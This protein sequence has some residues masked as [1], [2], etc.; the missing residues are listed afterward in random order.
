MCFGGDGSTYDIGLQS[1]SGAL[2]RGHDFL[3]VCYNNE[4]YMNTGG[5]RSGA[6]PKGAGTTTTPSGSKSSGKIQKKK[7]M[8]EI[9]IA[10]GIPYAA[11]ASIFNL[12]DLQ[13]KV[14][15][16]TLNLKRK[17]NID[18]TPSYCLYNKNKKIINYIEI[19]EMIKLMFTWKPKNSL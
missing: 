19:K 6:T 9:V 10:H 18:K 1:L 5:Q 15:K 17:H 16:S 2:E 4:G 7:D 3:Y 12:F 8:M 14:K 11:S 13:N